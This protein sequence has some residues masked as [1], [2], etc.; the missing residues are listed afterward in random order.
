MEHTDISDITLVYSDH[1]SPPSHSSLGYG[2]IDLDMDH[3]SHH[4]PR[5]SMAAADVSVGSKTDA[6]EMEVDV[7]EGHV[8]NLNKD[9]FG[10]QE[11]EDSILDDDI[12]EKYSGKQGCLL[13][14]KVVQCLIG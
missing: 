14:L 7:E 12:I 10:L 5:Q 1:P 11:W 3:S 13:L 4:D 9:L 8:T 2:R 6:G